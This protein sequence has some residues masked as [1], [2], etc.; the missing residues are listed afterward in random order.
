MARVRQVVRA[1]AHLV[2]RARSHLSGIN[3]LS[4]E[5]AELSVRAKGGLKGRKVDFLQSPPLG[6]G[7]SF[8]VKENC[9][10]FT[11]AEEAV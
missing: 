11:M 4:L 7:N 3:S 10:S 6:P 1:R 8:V 2:V 5:R 9:G